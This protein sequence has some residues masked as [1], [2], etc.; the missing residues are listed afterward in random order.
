MD[1]IDGQ[2]ALDTSRNGNGSP[3]GEI[4]ATDTPGTTELRPQTSAAAPA[5]AHI[6]QLTGIRALAALGVLTFHFR[7]ELLSA[8]PFLWP[9]VPMFN[10]GYL[11]VDLFFVLS[12]FILTYTHI[13]RMTDH[14]GPRKVVGFLWLRLSRI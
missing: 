3:T 8:F 4:P 13:E 12:G 14:Y 1:T 11:G 10:V 6:R 5:A 7:P 9:A 2:V